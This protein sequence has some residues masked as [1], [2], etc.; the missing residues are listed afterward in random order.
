MWN[1]PSINPSAKNVSAS[2]YSLNFSKDKRNAN[3][4]I[5]QIMKNFIDFFQLI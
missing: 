1:N 5:L 4:W 3:F 2:M